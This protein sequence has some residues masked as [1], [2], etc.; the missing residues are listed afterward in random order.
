[1]CGQ[2]L[3]LPSHH[4][5]L[6]LLSLGSNGIPA[7]MM[8]HHMEEVKHIACRLHGPGQH[9]MSNEHRHAPVYTCMLFWDARQVVN[10]PQG[11]AMLWKGS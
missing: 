9:L 2:V 6:L 3:E 4:E 1:M 5:L 8:G 11:I 7:G 10:M